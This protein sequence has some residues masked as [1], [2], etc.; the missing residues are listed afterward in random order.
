MPAANLEALVGHL[1]IVGGRS[2]SASSPGA[3]AM[4]A[5]RRTARGRDADTLF[6]LF[7]LNAEQRQPASFYEQLSGDLS[8][9]YFSTTGS[10]TA[11]L[12]EAI[13]AVNTSLH[14]D[15]S[16]GSEPSAVGLACAILREQ[17]LIIGLVGPARCFV[18][19][20]GV[21]ERLPTEDEYADG[22]R[23]LGADAEPDIRLYRRE[24]LANDFVILCDASLDAVHST[25]IQQAVG[26]G[27]VDTALNNLRSVSGQFT[28]AEV[29]KFVAPLSEDEAVSA[30]I[31]SP[32]ADEAAPRAATSHPAAED[33]PVFSSRHLPMARRAGRGVALSLAGAVSGTQ[34]LIRKMMPD[35]GM[36]NPLEE[37]FQM[38]LT[39]QI[40]VAVGVAIVIAVVTTVV[41]QWRGQTSQYAQLIGEAEKE[42]EQAHAGGNDQGAARPHWETALYL[43]DQAAQIRAS[44]PEVST[45][46]S[47]AQAALDSYDHV[48]RVDPVL[49]RAYPSGSV[50]KG[51]IV[52]GLNL[53]TIDTTNDIL[54]R[55]DLDQ[56]GTSLVN[57]DPQIVA[58]QG[59]LLNNQPVG[60]LINLTWMEDGGV[61]QKNILA[62]LSRNGLLITYSPSWSVSAVG[63]P[64]FE[65]WQDPRAI[66]VY[67]RDLY[68][69]DA[70]ANEIWRYQA[71]SDSYSSLPQR[72]FTDVTPQFGDAIDMKIDTNGNIF[73]LHASGQIN[74]Y[75]FGREQSF[76]FVGLPQPIA[77]PTALT[78]SLNLID[79]VFYIA[80]KGGERLY[81]TALNGTF[82]TNLK[83][84]QG[85]IFKSIGGVASQDRPPVMY[86]VAGNNLYYFPRPQ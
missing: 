41:Y 45:L 53:Y 46:R 69:L 65:A 50:L 42:V 25:A 57:H 84:R 19:H 80:D 61:P 36:D 32:P 51:P 30:M 86:I 10:L 54:Y 17:E 63:L 78:L 29:I 18:I 3:I 52:Q 9:K 66:A 5:P 22:M 85:T 28:S 67:N 39:T 12:K 27:E 60:G 59:D 38:P 43:V 64:G 37:R 48:T 34:T 83:D 20:A 21:I 56:N 35:L 2:I 47:E 1:F 49:L 79:R 58:R 23:A 6:G 55:E 74:K 68:I 24:I 8:T 72:Y 44:G 31:P 73:V 75:F 40:G 4:A 70:G 81:S 16:A 7:S 76:D 14:R 26:E 13:G 82:L 33:E 71:G 77:Q 62:V 15:L 11:A